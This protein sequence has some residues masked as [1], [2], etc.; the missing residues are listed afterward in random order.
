MSDHQSMS[1]NERTAR[2]N[3][4][5]LTTSIVLLI[6]L[7]IVVLPLLAHLC[8]ITTNTLNAPAP[9]LA[10]L[11]FGTPYWVVSLIA[12]VIIAVLLAKE[13]LIRTAKWALIANA[14]SCLVIL[15]TGAYVIAVFSLPIHLIMKSMGA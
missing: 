10:E 5:A 11:Y 8:E 1:F 7:L 15:I 6:V 12:A 14:F 2:A 3:A 4:I 9:R 13:W